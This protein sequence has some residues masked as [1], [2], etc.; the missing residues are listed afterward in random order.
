MINVRCFFRMSCMT[1]IMEKRHA[2]DMKHTAIP[3]LFREHALYYYI[4]LHGSK[5]KENESFTEWQVADFILNNDPHY[6]NLYK[7]RKLNTGNRI[8]AI[9]KTVKRNIPALLKQFLLEETGV[10][11]ETKGTSLIP[12]YALTPLG[13]LISRILQALELE[14]GMAEKELL[15]TILDSTSKVYDDSHPSNL[16]NSKLMKKMQEKGFFTN[17][18]SA[19]RE[20]TKSK[21]IEDI[22]SF[23]SLIQR[24]LSLTFYNP[25]LGHQFIDLRS[26]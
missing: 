26:A 21:Q 22:E 6:R 4:L 8:G 12:T 19:L 20:A 14:N 18:V 25:V 5:L 10:Q 1:F 9:V 17:Y 24:A 13:R 3:S 16:F 15:S 7:G 11:K 23:I 2:F